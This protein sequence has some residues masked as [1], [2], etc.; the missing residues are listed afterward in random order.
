MLWQ[1]RTMVR[2]CVLVHVLTVVDGTTEELVDLL[3]LKAFNLQQFAK[4]FDADIEVDPEMLDRYSVG[5]DDVPFL[6]QQLGRKLSFD[7]QRFAYFIEA[8]K[9]D[10]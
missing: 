8:A 5:P 2:Q 1:S 3:E 4:Q 6:E 10:S 9:K 7:F